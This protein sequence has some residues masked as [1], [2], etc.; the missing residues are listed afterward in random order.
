MISNIS[1]DEISSIWSQ[2][3]W[4]NRKSP[5]ETHSAM[6]F[7][8][9]DVAM[10]NFL[11]PAWYHGI[12]DLGVLAGVNSGHMCIDGSA[13]SR[14]LYVFPEYRGKGYGRVLLRATIDQAT[15]EGALFA[16]S[17]PR[18][19]SWKTY[20]SAGFTLVSDWQRSETSAANAYCKIFL[21]LENSQ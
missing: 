18:D 3:L 19:T 1:F 16:W 13:R 17:F 2:R 15:K 8:S 7:K 11:L 4:P 9:S 12:Y 14:G 21:R 6:L 5:I 20:E 10:G